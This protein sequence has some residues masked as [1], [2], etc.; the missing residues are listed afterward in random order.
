LG[1]FQYGGSIHCLIFRP[2]VIARFAPGTRPAAKN[3]HA[4]AVK[5]GVPLAAA[6]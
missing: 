3:P 1:Y 2:G 6:R 5:L 4:P